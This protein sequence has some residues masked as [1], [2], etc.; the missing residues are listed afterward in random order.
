MKML[1]TIDLFAKPQ[2]DE[3]GRFVKGNSESIGNAGKPCFFCRDREHYLKKINLY[4]LWT[5]GKLD[6]KPHMPYF[7]MLCDEDYLDISYDTF[8]DWTNEKDQHAIENHAELIQI[9]KKLMRRQEGYLLQRTLSSAATGAIFQ[10]KANHGYIETEKRILAGDPEKP[11]NQKLE[12][13]IIDAKR[14]E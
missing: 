4:S 5:L 13:E 2:R 11:V 14:N 1:Q 10:L 3:K 7:Q 6:K 8:L 12:I 9:R